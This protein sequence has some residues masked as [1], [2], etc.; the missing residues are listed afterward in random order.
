MPGAETL[1]VLLHNELDDMTVQYEQ[2]VVKDRA[3]LMT[4]T[5]QSDE[6]IENLV[7]MISEPT[8]H[9]FTAKQEARYL[10]Q[11]KENLQSEQCI[12]LAD[13][14][15]NYSFI[16]QDAAQGFHC[17]NNQ[18]IFHLFIVHIKDQHLQTLSICV[19]SDCL[20]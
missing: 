16:F 5:Q 19:F 13:F 12:I 6:L 14:S 4:V 18:A 9:H 20:D 11:S 8:H 2:W 7:C 10:K 3:T 17:A 15:K 1:E